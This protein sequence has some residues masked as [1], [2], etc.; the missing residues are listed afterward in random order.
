MSSENIRLKVHTT[1][2]EVSLKIFIRKIVVAL[3]WLV[4]ALDRLWKL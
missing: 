1:K 4:G 3:L 2:Q